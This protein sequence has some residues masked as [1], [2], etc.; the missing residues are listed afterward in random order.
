MSWLR[1]SGATSPATDDVGSPAI[2]AA[3]DHA[4]PGLRQVM[5]RLPR[6]G[7]SVL[8]FGPVLAAN[9]ECFRRLQARLRL[10]DLEGTL[11]DAGLWEKPAKLSLW[12]ESLPR[13]LAA[14]A[15]E[16][17][18]LVLAWDFPNYL[19]R[20]R[21]PA[22]ARLLVERLKPGGVV[23][24]LARSGRSM[25][26]RPGHFRITAG[27]AV[28]EEPRTGATL[29]PPRFS[30]GEIE[31]LNPGL[32]AARSFLDK[33]GVQEFVLEH[34]GELNLPPRP[35]AQLRKPRSYYPG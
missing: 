27:E 18:D 35:I 14:G 12:E 19:G 7:A 24:L 5:E 31:R 22:L 33:H 13:L 2:P 11:V 8:D 34:A 9:I 28:R 17:Y 1:R 16:H 6:P 23:H 3:I 25:P 21:W 10:L 29:E 26:A 20:E 30:H 4:S 32:A 15:D